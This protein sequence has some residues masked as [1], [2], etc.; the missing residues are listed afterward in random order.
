VANTFNKNNT[1]KFY[2]KITLIFFLVIIPQISSAL[3]GFY[4]GINLGNHEGTTDSR[5]TSNNNRHDNHL[6]GKSL[7]LKLGYLKPMNSLITG[8]EISFEDHKTQSVGDC[9]N[10]SYECKT[11]INST[12][13]LKAKIGY[14]LQNYPIVPMMI[15]GITEN[16]VMIQQRRKDGS[17]QHPGESNVNGILYGLG[18]NSLLNENTLLGISYT[19]NELNHKNIM[20]SEPSDIKTKIK[21]ETIGVSLT[22]LF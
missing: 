15:V 9:P 20:S 6:E 1:S 18:I 19:W 14:Q 21:Y 2:K 7:G 22:Y 4:G 8:A 10:A 16:K 11:K 17:L 5:F 3:E 12:M 13:A